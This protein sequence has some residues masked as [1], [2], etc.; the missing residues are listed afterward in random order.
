MVLPP[1][2]TGSGAPAPGSPALHFFL[3]LADEGHGHCHDH[4]YP[5]RTQGSRERAKSAGGD[6]GVQREKGSHGDS[7]FAQ[8]IFSSCGPGG[9]ASPPPPPAPSP[10]RPHQGR[11]VPDAGSGANTTSSRFILSSLLSFTG[12][13]SSHRNLA[14]SQPQGRLLLFPGSIDQY[15]RRPEPALRRPRPPQ[16][17]C[18]GE[19]APR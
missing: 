19:T 17:N 3:V 11:L 10:A 1:Y 2:R 6:D 4:Q 8:V 14:V 5:S 13:R 18:S 7:S 9:L 16:G 12:P 15:R